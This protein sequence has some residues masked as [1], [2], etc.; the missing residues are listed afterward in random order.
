MKWAVSMS[1]NVPAEVVQLAEIL[2]DNIL[3][4]LMIKL[5]LKNMKIKYQV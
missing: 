3:L 5:L 4:F 2:D 1:Q